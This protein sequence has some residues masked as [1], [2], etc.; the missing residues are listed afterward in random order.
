MIEN[1]RLKELKLEM[2]ILRG[3]LDAL[4]I[5]YKNEILKTF[6]EQKNLKEGEKFRFNGKIIYK[7][8]VES[9]YYLLGYYL[10]KDGSPSLSHIIIPTNCNIEKI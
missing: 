5:K 10:K 8:K 7:L 6:L 2:S 1:K 4:N 3:K 9:E